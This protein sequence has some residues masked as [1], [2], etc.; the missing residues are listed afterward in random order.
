MSLFKRGDVWH[1]DFWF[2]GRRYFGSTRQVVRANAELVERDVKRHLRQRTAGLEPAPQV[3]APR[4]Q[5]WAEIHYRER[6]QHMT[7]P[8]FL[9]DNLRVV[10]RFWGERP[11]R[12]SVPEDPYHNL[13]L[14]DPIRNPVWIER[15][16]AWMRAR[17]SSPQ[18][19]N[20]YRSTLRGMYRTALLPAYRGASGLTVN[21]FRDVPRETIFERT[22]TVTVQQL[23]K[24]LAQASY[25]VRLAVAIAALAPK[26]RLANILSL[27]WADS[28]D[29]D[30]RYITVHRHKTMNTLRRPQV[31]P[32]SEQLRIILRDA[33]QRTRVHIVEYRGKPVKSVRGGLQEAARRAGVPFG[34]AV[35]GATFHTLRHTA[36]SLLAELGE[37]EAIRKEVMGHRNIATTQRYT[38]LRPIH[39]IPAHERLAEAVPIADLVT[40]PRK[41]ASN[42]SVGTFVGTLPGTLE[43]TQGKIVIPEKVAESG[44]RM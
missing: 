43:E 34:R 2:E 11:M 44:H 6:A 30:L 24:W 16:E 42:K 13:R 4:F 37:P 29:P 1:Y 3:T 18:T 14:H 23:R 32:I 10:L 41:R 20:H 35:N 33:R 36:A 25:H 26:L 8:E 28:V 31:V 15:F 9:E 12:G 21:P 19:R 38:H 27:T 40:A 5:D 17:G 39:E 7:R 22:V